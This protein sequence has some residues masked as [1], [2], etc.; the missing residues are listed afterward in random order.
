MKIVTEVEFSDKAIENLLDSAS[1]GSAYWCDGSGV[2]AYESKT[3]KAI[4]K[5]ITID[6]GADG[7]RLLNRTSIKTGLSL[8]AKKFP[9]HFN[10]IVIGNDD[11][12]TADIFLQLAL[13]NDVIYE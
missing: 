5:G 4:T 12:N 9:I 2:L 8:M 13:L 11:A 10:D 6:C 1:R 3:K 7:K